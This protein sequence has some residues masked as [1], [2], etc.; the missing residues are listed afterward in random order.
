MPLSQLA[1]AR[2]VHQFAK[3]KSADLPAQED[4]W[5]YR[6]KSG[7]GKGYRIT[8]LTKLERRN[9][10]LIFQPEGTWLSADSDLNKL[11]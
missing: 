10:S 8:K 2:A 11:R 9:F 6:K 5:F 1:L 4:L 7:T 3:F